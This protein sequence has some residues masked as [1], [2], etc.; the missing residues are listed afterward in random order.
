MSQD[1]FMKKYGIA[2]ILLAMIVFMCIA[3]PTFRTSG[4]VISILQ[5]ISVNGVLA[6]GMV[7]VIT[8][9]GIDLSI[10]SML[11][12]T[13][14]VIGVVFEY[15]SSIFVAA[16]VSVLMCGLFGLLN[17]V[18]IAKFN[19]FPFVVTLATQLV[20]RGT[21]Y[22]ISDGATKT[23]TN[24]NFR[25]IG[26]GKLF[27]VVPYSILIFLVMAVIAFVL[28][29]MTKFGRHIYAV[30]GNINAARASGVKVFRTRVLS[31]VWMGVCAAVAGVILTSRIN[32]AQ[33]NIGEGYETDA[34]AACVIG[35]TSFAGGVSTI[36]G[37]MIGIVIIGVI[38]NGMNL[39]RVSSYW[40]TI[41]KGVLI[42]GAV[43]LD[44]FLNKKKN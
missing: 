13:S 42:I 9:G 5:Q 4:N 38:Y 33:P 20:I 1:V 35:G 39:L 7:F 15:T 3:S 14:V 2:I 40:Q 22:I 19:M 24:K 12:L 44:M 21:G 29:H 31:F 34:I 10:G 27:G 28:L 17:G 30:G 41:T 25:Q 11:A 37:T 36:P 32:A 43:M 26:L 6:L 18:L 8:A 23:L 16:A